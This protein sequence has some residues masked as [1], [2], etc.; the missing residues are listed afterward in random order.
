ML[1][2]MGQQ[3]L[4]VKVKL[5][6]DFL[7]S[8]PKREA[9]VT[10]LSKSVSPN[11]QSCAAGTAILGEDKL[12]RTEFRVGTD[13][14]VPRINNLR[15]SADHPIAIA[16]RKFQI[17]FYAMSESDNQIN[18]KNNANKNVKRN[19]P[20]RDFKSGIAMPVTKKLVYGFA[21]NLDVK[22]L[23]K[24]SEFFE[25][26]QKSLMLYESLVSEGRRKP[27][28]ESALGDSMSPRQQMI[29]K[30]IKEGKSNPEIADELSYSVSLIR[31]ESMKIYGKLGVTGRKEVISKNQK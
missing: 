28:S 14:S 10:Y 7:A 31:Q 21:F 30:L 29:L 15:A 18:T 12:I 19:Q 1:R 20:N 23:K 13:K 25:C 26:V 4:Y 22:D 17:Q 11:D 24:Y 5:L 2:D 27:M 3:S 9:I 8:K 16:L 6:L